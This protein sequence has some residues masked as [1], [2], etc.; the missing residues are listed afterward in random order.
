MPEIVA[1]PRNPM[2]SYGTSWPTLPDTGKLPL[3]GSPFAALPRGKLVKVAAKKKSPS[4]AS[5]AG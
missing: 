1:S 2:V 3:P 4:S 5:I